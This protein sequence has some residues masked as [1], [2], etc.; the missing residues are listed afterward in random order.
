MIK[1]YIKRWRNKRGFGVHSPF[2][3]HL[4]TEIIRDKYPYYKFETIDEA[5]QDY[6]LRE[7]RHIK[8]KRFYLLFRIL[9]HLNSSKILE[10]G[11]YNGL[12][13]LSMALCG[14]DKT[15]DVFPL[16][17]KEATVLFLLKEKYT[18]TNVNVLK[19][20]DFENTSE[21]YDFIYIHA[22]LTD[23]SL[24][25]SYKQLK[26]LLAENG[27]ILVDRNSKKRSSKHEWK[28]ILKYE[29][30]QMV[31]D[32]DKRALLFFDKKLTPNKYSI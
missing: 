22:P 28:Q 2:A 19:T 8:T 16:K 21:K 11:T 5:V 17:E 32:Q 25:C 14:Q 20:I 1:S 6:C 4:I 23:M 18:L 10:V 13:T 12:S 24:L 30:P 26:P 3:F 29:A 7:N 27:V 9:N 31:I 15:I